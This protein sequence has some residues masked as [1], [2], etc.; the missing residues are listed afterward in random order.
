[1]TER[2][3]TGT[4]NLKLNVLKRTKQQGDVKRKITVVFIIV[5]KL[6]MDPNVTVYE[7]EPIPQF[8]FQ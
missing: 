3:N 6:K 8:P 1:M 7:H 5:S 4:I 2:E